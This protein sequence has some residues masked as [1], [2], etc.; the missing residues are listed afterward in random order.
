MLRWLN[1]IWNLI[2]EEPTEKVAADEKTMN[3]VRHWTHK[4]IKIVTND[5]ERMRFNVM[6]AALMEYTNH[7]GKVKDAVFNTDAWQEAVESLILMLA[8]SAPHFAEELWQRLGRS[9]SVHNQTFPTYEEK[10]AAEDEITLVVQVNGKVRARLNAPSSIPEAEAIDMALSD[11]NIKAHTQG[12]T[13]V[14]KI[15]VPGKLV[16]IVV[17]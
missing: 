17:K 14:K 5:L 6:L 9:Y 8:P 12:R 2:L 13:I 3:D 10:L 7:L 16:N 4:T 1:R 11:D 15:Y